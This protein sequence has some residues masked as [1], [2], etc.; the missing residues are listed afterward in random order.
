MSSRSYISYVR[1]WIAST[2]HV[3][4]RAGVLRRVTATFLAL[5][6]IGFS[7]ETLI[8]DVHDGDASVAEV[9]AAG[10]FAAEMADQPAGIAP[11]PERHSGEAPSTGHSAHV[12]HCIHAHGGIPGISATRPVIA[13]APSH[14]SG[15]SDRMP[16]SVT[17]EPRIR[18]PQA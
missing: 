18:P 5:A 11:A 17:V 15:A 12:C 9:E 16:A 10:L 6:F 14:V 1:A 8:A 7:A 3:A 13:D 4:K 2:R